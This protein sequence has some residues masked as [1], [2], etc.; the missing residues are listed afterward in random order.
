MFGLLALVLLTMLL[1]YKVWMH[2]ETMGGYAD[3]GTVVGMRLPPGNQLV[4]DG[5]ARPAIFSS[6]PV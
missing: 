1:F 4:N 2:R 6:L 5:H 3:E